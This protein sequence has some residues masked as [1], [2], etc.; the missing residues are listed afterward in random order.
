[1][2]EQRVVRTYPPAPGYQDDQTGLS[3]LKVMLRSGYRVV[4]VNKIGRGGFEWLEYIV[5][6]E[7]AGA[8]KTR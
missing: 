6:K 7:E 2:G 4:T 1:M 5:E 8:E 3:N